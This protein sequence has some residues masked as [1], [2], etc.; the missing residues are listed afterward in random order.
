M[1]TLLTAV[2]DH[3]SL[4]SLQDAESKIRKWLETIPIGDL[5]DLGLDESWNHSWGTIKQAP[6]PQKRYGPITAMRCCWDSC[7]W[8][9]ENKPIQYPLYSYHPDY[10][11]F[12]WNHYQ[13][14]ITY[15][16]A[17]CTRCLSVRRAGSTSHLS[18]VFLSWGNGSERGW[19]DAQIR[20]IATFAEQRQLGHLAP[21]ELYQRPGEF[22]LCVHIL[23]K[24]GWHGF[25]CSSE[26]ELCSG[27]W[28]K[29][30][31]NF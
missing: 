11:R 21:E 4:M 6:H 27:S 15:W 29:P 16:G 1:S 23:H 10:H 26:C 5:D 7:C 9:E 25:L 28:L 13:L 14:V 24:C 31:M 18:C 20:E 19:D 17:Y 22:F 12:W 2:D 3:M 30:D 8:D